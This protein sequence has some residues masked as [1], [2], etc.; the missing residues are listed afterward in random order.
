M[1]KPSPKAPTM[2]LQKTEYYPEKWLRPHTHMHRMDM[3]FVL[4]NG[5]FGDYICWMPAL[6]WLM[7]EAKWIRGT[8]L[9]PIYFKELAEYWMREHADWKLHDY[10]E[11]ASLPNLN[12]MAFRG[13]VDLQRESLNAT[14]AHLLTCGWVYFTN[15]EGPPPGYDCYPSIAQSYLDTVELPAPAKS[16]I[17][18][19][20]AIFTVGQTT[21]SRQT[22]RGGWNAVLEHVRNLGLTPVFLGKSVIETGNAKNIHTRFDDANRYDLGVDLRDQ[23][24]LMQAAAIM[25]R[26]AFV[27]GHDN[28]LLH[29]AACTEVPI[30]FGYNIAAPEHRR[31]RRLVG[32][33]VDVT[34]KQTELSC[35]H[36]QSNVNFII[37]YNFRECFYSDLKCMS[38]LFENEGARWKSAID[39]ALK[40]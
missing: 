7:T 31:P 15:K 1:S 27:I 36:C 17:R 14:G 8:I 9:A 12:N 37:G 23:T 34:L 22:P 38:M 4:I 28:G 18:G 30:V 24:T 2:T 11:I 39:E 19:K 3:A 35:I 29:L 16:L 26:A 32:K 21:N 20:Y 13:P 25:A 10:K 33:T 6:Q 5:G 40:P